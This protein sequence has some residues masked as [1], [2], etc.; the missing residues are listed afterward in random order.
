MAVSKRIRFEV[1]RRDN[2]SCRY[3]GAK[4]P[5]VEL[6][7]DHVMPVALG[8]SDDP[9]NLTT[10]CVDCNNGKAST[11]PDDDVV[12]DVSEDAER[13]ARALKVAGE[14]LY[15]TTD[16]EAAILEAFALVW[17]DVLA[18]NNKPHA[19]PDNWE[20][21]VLNYY[22]GG[23]PEAKIIEAARV[24]L[25]ARNVQSSNRF[26]YFC[27]VCKRRTSEIAAYAQKLIDD[28]EVA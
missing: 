24:A 23:L 1:L 6:H 17:G 5:D 26:R 3:C 10:A 14:R 15:K 2:F 4:A 11:R 18:W 28:G 9:T 22:Y 13:W 20:T 21:A 27:G 8:G 25:S 7:V 16:D 12:E 19:L